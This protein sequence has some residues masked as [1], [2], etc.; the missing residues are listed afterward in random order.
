[1]HAHVEEYLRYVTKKFPE[2]MAQ[3]VTWDLL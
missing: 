3:P 2:V 1:M